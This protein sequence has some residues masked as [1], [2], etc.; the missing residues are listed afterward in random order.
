[1]RKRKNQHGDSDT[2]QLDIQRF[3]IG[4]IEDFPSHIKGCEGFLS[5]E[6]Y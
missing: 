5:F 4:S 1:M 3:D 2:K 6:R